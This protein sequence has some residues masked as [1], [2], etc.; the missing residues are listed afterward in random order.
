M[1]TA[2]REDYA[3]L[4]STTE[5]A[6]QYAKQHT[7]IRWLS[8]K[9][10]AVR[11]Q[12]QYDSIKKYFLTFFP[13]EK[14]FKYHI[15]PTERYKRIENALKDPLPE[16]YIALCAFSAGGFELFLLTFQSDE[17]KIH[18]LYPA[19]CKLLSSLMNKFIRK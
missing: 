19:M 12:E 2:R 1:A 6:A 9:Y 17:P 8:M 4:E 16:G 10:V 7:E 13:K 11:M 14:S 18:I 15:K 3:S 5:I